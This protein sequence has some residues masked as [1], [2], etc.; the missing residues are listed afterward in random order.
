MCGD[1]ERV[2]NQPTQR[3]VKAD[4]MVI[5]GRHQARKEAA[6]WKKQSMAPRHKKDMLTL[7]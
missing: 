7:E 3:D 1:G 5:K 4:V 2:S 6:C